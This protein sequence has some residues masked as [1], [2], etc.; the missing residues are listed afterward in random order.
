M[1]RRIITVVLLTAGLVGAGSG[2]QALGGN[3]TQAGGYWGCLGVYASDHSICLKNP[4][5][6][7]LP[8]PATPSTPTAG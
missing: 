6:E 1:R 2:A 3:S 8:V 5:P 7:R 4:L